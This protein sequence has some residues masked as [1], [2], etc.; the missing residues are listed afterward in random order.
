MTNLTKLHIA[1][2]ILK[3]TDRCLKNFDCLTEGR[4]LCE[5]SQSLDGNSLIIQYDKNK[6]CRYKASIGNTILCTCP[7]RNELYNRYNI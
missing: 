5:V 6:P 1:E 2:S 7:T 3:S 4:C